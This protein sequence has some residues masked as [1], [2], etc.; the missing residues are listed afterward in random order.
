MN[1]P[2]PHHDASIVQLAEYWQAIWKERANAPVVQ[3][4]NQTERLTADYNREV[5]KATAAL[6]GLRANQERALASA[7]DNPNKEPGPSTIAAEMFAKRP[8]VVPDP[9]PDAA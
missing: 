8:A 9:G 4:A 2:E 7:R 5:A 3:S 6:W 1:I